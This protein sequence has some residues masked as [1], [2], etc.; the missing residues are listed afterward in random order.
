LSVSAGPRSLGDGVGLWLG[1]RI[2]GRDLRRG[3]LGLGGHRSSGALDGDTGRLASKAEHAAA[4]L[5][6]NLNVKVA[7]VHAK[8]LF[9]SSDGSLYSFAGYFY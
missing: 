7:A 9:G 1:S 3:R 4:P 2:R 6:Q 5:A 8:L